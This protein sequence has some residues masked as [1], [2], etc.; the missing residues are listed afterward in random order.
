MVIV[1][2]VAMAIVAALK[3]LVMITDLVV[4]AA[5]ILSQSYPPEPHYYSLMSNYSDLFLNLLN[6]FVQ[7]PLELIVPIPLVIINIDIT[8]MIVLINLCHNMVDYTWYY[9]I[10]VFC[11]ES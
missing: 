10:M 3:W 11:P 9:R 2:V 1:V 8:K 7:I 6:L 5:V 4:A